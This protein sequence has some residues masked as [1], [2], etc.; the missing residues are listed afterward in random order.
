M[1]KK[2]QPQVKKESPERP[3]TDREEVFCRNI[4]NGKTKIDSYVSAGYRNNNR[5]TA[6]QSAC[7]LFKKVKIQA[8]LEVLRKE[9]AAKY[10]LTEANIYKQCASILNADARNYTKWGP[11]GVTL[12][13]SEALTEAQA[14]AVEEVSETVTKEGGTVKFRLHSKVKAME[15]GAKLLSMINDKHEVNIGSATIEKILSA[16]PPALADMVRQKLMEI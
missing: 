13:D 14:L 3:L 7:R 6:Y 5:K 1:N 11:E 10:D 16:L 15:L 4:V 9:I 8:R 2:I 12:I